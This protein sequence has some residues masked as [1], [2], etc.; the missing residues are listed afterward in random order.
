MARL[1]SI[2]F[3]AACRLS[4]QSKG[5]PINNSHVRT[6]P[7]A[8]H[9]RQV[10]YHTPRVFKQKSTRNSTSKISNICTTTLCDYD[11]SSPLV[12]FLYPPFSNPHSPPQIA[13]LSPPNKHTHSNAKSQPAP[14]NRR[15]SPHRG[16]SSFFRALLLINTNNQRATTNLRTIPFTCQVAGGVG[17]FSR[18]GRE[19]GRAIAFPIVSSR[20]SAIGLVADMRGQELMQEEG[21]GFTNFV[22]SSPAKVSAHCFYRTAS[23]SPL[24]SYH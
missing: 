8:N 13:Q 11:P 9:K 2:A 18:Y 6:N 12:P 19:Q 20:Q 1:E 24:S 5:H 3:L 14:H 21:D 17:K 10:P 7:Q 15:I 4:I 22:Y 23:T 16:S